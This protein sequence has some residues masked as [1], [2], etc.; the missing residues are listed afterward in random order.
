MT[1][2]EFVVLLGGATVAT[3]LSVRAQ[4][5]AMPVIGYLGVGSAD[6]DVPLAAFRQGLSEAGYA[7]GQNVT[8]DYRWAEGNSERF[9]ALAAELVML[10]VNV[11]LT[12]GGTLAAKAAKRATATIPIVFTAV[13]DPVE[14]GLVASLARPGGNVTGFS[15]AL[16]DLIGKFLELIKEAVPGAS[17]VALLFK[18]D[19]MPD[20][21]R[22]ARLRMADASARALGVKLHVFEARGREDFEAAFSDMSKAGADALVV[23]ATPLFSLERRRLADLAAEHRL[24]AVFFNRSFVEAGGLMS[25]GPNIPDLNRRAAIYVGK[26]LKGTKPSDLPVEQPTKF[27]LVINFK[28]AKALGIAV[29]PS[30]LARADEVIE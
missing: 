12:T 19:T 9:P 3:P 25:Y 30:L 7:E 5:P 10:K 15:I 24:P 4:Q 21:V 11:I 14:E 13:G 22:E 27:E 16:P 20:R 17:Q 29:P 2:R 26:I 18:P 23:W 1:R 8:I 28:T 6:S